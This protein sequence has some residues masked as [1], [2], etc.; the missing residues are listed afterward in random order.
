MTAE[1]LKKLDRRVR[2]IPYPLGSN[3][4]LFRRI[5]VDT[6]QQLNISESDVI[7]QYVDWKYSRK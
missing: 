3:Y 1:E 4:P 7:R 6:S 2:V 5:F